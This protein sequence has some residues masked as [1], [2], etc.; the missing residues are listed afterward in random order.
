M[1]VIIVKV[2]LSYKN[3]REVYFSFPTYPDTIVRLQT[4]RDDN[5]IVRQIKIKEFKI[6]I[7]K[8]CCKVL[9][10]FASE[11]ISKDSYS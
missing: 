7:N 10:S 9:Y 3:K 4:F 1:V 5:K 2:R 8:I 11:L 6:D